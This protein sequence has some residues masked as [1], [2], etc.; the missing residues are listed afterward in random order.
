M[1][2]Q[3]GDWS[4]ASISWTVHPTYEHARL[5]VAEGDQTGQELLDEALRAPHPSSASSSN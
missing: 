3:S 5:V 1:G 2:D 4:A